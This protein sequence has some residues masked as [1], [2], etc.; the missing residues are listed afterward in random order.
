MNSCIT[1]WFAAS[2]GASRCAAM[3]VDTF[4]TVFIAID[5]TAMWAP[6]TSSGR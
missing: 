6:I 5:R 1:T 3:T 2:V 4:H